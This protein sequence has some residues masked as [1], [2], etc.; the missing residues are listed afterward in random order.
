MS[1]LLRC[2]LLAAFA[3]R[4]AA[5]PEPW[6]DSRL[7]V[8]NGLAFWLDA[9]RQTAARGT[10]GL[11]PLT[12]GAPVDIAFDGSGRRVRVV[13]PDR[14][15]R[16][17][18]QQEFSGA[19]FRFDGHNDA[20]V[21][22]DAGLTLSNFTVFIVAIPRSNPGEFRGFLA[23]AR[24]GANDYTSGFNLDL[25]PFPGGQ[26]SVVNAE[27]SGFG[28]AVNLLQ[29]TPLPFGVWRVFSAE[30][31]SD[32][33]RLH[34]D[35]RP[36][37]SRPRRVE[38]FTAGLVSVG[39]RYYSNIAEPPYVQGFLESSIAE[40]LIFDRTLP[41]AERARVD[42]YLN[43]K[44]AA[45][46]GREP[47]AERGS[48]P[49][50]T[51]TNPPPVQMFLPGFEVRRMPVDLPNINDVKYR[52]DGRLVALGY[53]GRIWLLRDT[54]GDGLEDR[55]DVFWEAGSL[56]APIGMALTPPGYLRG[57][58]V[59]VAAKG[60][61]SLIVDTN[62][63]D[64]A[65]REIIVAE[66]WKELS[67]GVDALGVAVAPSGEVYFGLG[68]A[69]YTD[70]YLVDK[71]SGRGRY[72][73]QS[74]RGTILR[75]AADFSRRDVV[76]TGVR[77][78]VALAFNAAG[79]LFCTD[80]EGAT[81]LANGNPLD[82]LLH[83]QAGRHYGFPP[84]HPQHLPDVVD[85][86][87]VFDYA[88]QHQ[89]T[90]GLNFNEPVNGGPVFGPASWRG[91]ALVTGYSRGKLWRTSLAKTKFGYVA[92]N[93]L[94][95]SLPMLAVDACV[96]P[97]GDL[98]VSA[99]GGEPDWGS[100]PTG[101]GRLYKI[102]HAD[103][104]AALPVAT[105]AA[106]PSEFRIAFDRPLDPVM[107]RDLT[108]RV[109]LTVGRWVGAGDRFETKRPGY[110]VV[111]QQLA[112]PRRDVPVISV[113]V[114]PDRRTLVVSTARVEIPGVVAITINGFGRTNA[115][116]PTL[117]QADDLD[118]ST[119]LSGVAAEWRAIRAA[120][121]PAWSGWLPHVDLGVV[122]A[123]TAGSADHDRLWD[124]SRSPGV[125][126][127]RGHL[128]LWQML[129][130]AIQPGAALDHERPVEKVSVTFGAA[131][132]FEGTWEDN[133]FRAAP[134]ASG[135]WEAKCA[136]ADG[137]KWASWSL[138][139]N[140]GSTNPAVTASWSTDADPRQRPFPLRRFLVPWA[141]PWEDAPSAAATVRPQ[142]A[143]DWSRGRGLFFGEKAVCSKC[144]VYN[145]NGA[146]VGP[147][148]SNLPQR[149]EA[150]VRNDIIH[151]NAALNP[152][153]L[154]SV[155][156]F[157]DGSESTVV[158]QSESQGNLVLVGP[159]GRDV[160]PRSR[161][162]SIRPSPLSLMPEG[163]DRV[164]T[165]SEFDDLIAFLLTPP[166]QAATIRIAGAPEP[167]TPAEI[168]PL[169]SAPDPAP[170]AA[171]LPIVLCAGP[172]DHG[173]DE[174]DYPMWRDRWARLLAFGENV[175][176]S[177]AWEWP[178]EEQ[179]KTARVVVFYSDNPGWDT[180]HA[181]DM[182][183]FL[184]RSNGVVMLHWAV[185]GHDHPESL[186]QIIGLA[187]RGGA[188]KFR[189]GPLA[190][191][192]KPGPLTTGLAGLQLVDE[193]YW[194][195]VGDPSRIDV[196]ASAVEEGSSR[197]LVWTR[198]HGPGRVFVCIPGHYTW[199]FDDPCYRA[200]VLRGIA[201]SAGEPADRL[202]SLASLGARIH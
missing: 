61:V 194:N 37:G 54:D 8:T 41:D 106:G 169:L 75:V 130:P 112:D 62:A 113:Q 153:H 4:L 115:P 46:L 138:A 65:D 117:P 137:R 84:R 125:L 110:A 168:A 152:D 24:F 123:F 18:F 88:P 71:A 26:L 55:A 85:E 90:C 96:S 170:A 131:V 89:S 42:A 38:P 162:K 163:F 142:L 33:V 98:V 145:G 189:H 192:V 81:W 51:V 122:R 144:H 107:L 139:V 77:F 15:A 193:S 166:L 9:S 155:I 86:P 14:D 97:E 105:W 16:P 11:P 99:H 197:P 196:V 188:S 133:P 95:G 59:F 108:R 68:A 202:T 35:G 47:E 183:A 53:D 56:R 111:Y 177:T 57:N 173:V 20:L 5:G 3:L 128:D 195:L 40:L 167:R 171:P 39:A 104:N 82:E 28:G 31:G 176:A 63:D 30:A 72:S 6:A 200:L 143:G 67:H 58:G 12:S 43:D 156:E 22:T 159:G 74:E 141:R 185:D 91:D 50:V 66:G 157:A 100:G 44:Y 165:P 140:T 93:A 27:G 186:A 154:A 36:H 94:L 29:G 134:G 92:R 147:D 19:F 181:R 190:L 45:L 199:T 120:D 119:D 118:L 180:A 135:L 34:V 136:F 127:L 69:S 151:P 109:D 172:K 164:L 13:Q 178:S 126:T 187:W 160:V 103:T 150:G 32:V 161:I 87:S 124:A 121:A 80:Q 182:E 201:W 76:C 158:I 116:A 60:K 149:D 78:S 2:A 146:A 101:D 148:L 83:I 70:P 73:L 21:A 114:T 198:Q 1:R 102:R 23:L 174:H 7:S 175:R 129:Q 17:H 184:A 48:K 52:A 132:P 49:L 79:D 179:W 10:F 64:R 25:G 191:D